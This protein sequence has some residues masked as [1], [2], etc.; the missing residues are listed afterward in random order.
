M[1]ICQSKFPRLFFYYY[2]L[3][4]KG[5]TRKRQ[6][7][8]FHICLDFN[9]IRSLLLFFKKWHKINI[10]FDNTAST[11]RICTVPWIV[12]RFLIANFKGYVIKFLLAILFLVQS[13]FSNVNPCKANKA[14]IRNLDVI[15]RKRYFK[16]KP[17]IVI[18]QKYLL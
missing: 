1:S 17:A 8:L 16:I 15:A 9:A 14:N 4:V 11:W 5:F 12:K 13:I 3:V 6:S 2:E 7:H 10:S 18:L